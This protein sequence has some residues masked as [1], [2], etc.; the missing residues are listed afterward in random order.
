MAQPMRSPLD[1]AQT[2][3]LQQL[4]YDGELELIVAEG[5]ASPTAES[6]QVGDKQLQGLHRFQVTEN[7][8]AFKVLFSHCIAWQV[9]DENYTQ[10]DPYEIKA[11][12]GKLRTLSRSRYLD[13]IIAYHGRFQD[14]E[15][16]AKHYRV[17]TEDEVI[18]VVACEPPQVVKVDGPHIPGR[19][20]QSVSFKK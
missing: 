18:D 9:L 20:S 3:Y 19:K 6:L 5:L 1:Q 8:Q 13:H 4:R 11:D 2:L 17:W 10:F 14:I 12:D 15:G 16:P 7:S